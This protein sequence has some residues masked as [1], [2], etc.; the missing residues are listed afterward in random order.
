[1]T[2][3]LTEKDVPPLHV[4]APGEAAKLVS[5]LKAHAPGS[6]DTQLLA[7]EVYLRRGRLLLALAAVQ[8]AV[9]LA[10]AA[11]P[12]VHLAL[13]KLCS[14]GEACGWWGTPLH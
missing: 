3:Y 5:S 14:Q 6:L 4:Y 12:A 10:G 11:H 8:R 1:L 9:A 2:H 13:I 7:A